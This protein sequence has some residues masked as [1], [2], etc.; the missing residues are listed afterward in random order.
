MKKSYKY[1]IGFLFLSKDKTSE[2]L[3]TKKNKRLQTPENF[4]PDRMVIDFKRVQTNN[5]KCERFYKPISKFRC[6]IR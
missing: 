2:N 4:F 3:R 6:F 5:Y 1:P